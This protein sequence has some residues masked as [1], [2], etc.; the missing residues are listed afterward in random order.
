M[1]FLWR[2]HYP[3]YFSFASHRHSFV[4]GEL[5]IPK[6]G[7]MLSVK[8]SLFEGRSIIL[9][10]SGFTHLPQPTCFYNLLH[11]KKRMKLYLYIE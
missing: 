11:E 6:V 9:P 3:A 8:F 10:L 5:Y 7:F 2:A 1:Q 4:R